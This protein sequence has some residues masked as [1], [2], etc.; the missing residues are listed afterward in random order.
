M[1]GTPNYVA[2]ETLR[3]EAVSEKVDNFAIGVIIFFM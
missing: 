3:R 1:L 2:P